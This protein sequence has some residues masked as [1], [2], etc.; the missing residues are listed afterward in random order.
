MGR[1]QRLVA[2]EAAAWV[3]V[4]ETPRIPSLQRSLLAQYGDAG[5]GA[6]PDAE[7]PAKLHKLTRERKLLLFLDDVWHKRSK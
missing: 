1:S 3:T 6:G 2:F 7:L 4:G 5:G